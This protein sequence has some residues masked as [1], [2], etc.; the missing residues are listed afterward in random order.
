MPACILRTFFTICR[1]ETRR[2]DEV[3]ASDDDDDDDNET[4]RIKR[5]RMNDLLT[6]CSSTR[7]ARVM[8]SRTAPAERTPPYARVTDFLFF[9]MCLLLYLT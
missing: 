5:V 9:A 4:R 7:K 8:R 3:S 6:F 2:W 1:R